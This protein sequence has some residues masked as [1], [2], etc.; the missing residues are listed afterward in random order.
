[1]N[2]AGARCAATFVVE[3]RV[4]RCR[5]EPSQKPSPLDSIRAPFQRHL[6]LNAVQLR[7]TSPSSL[8]PSRQHRLHCAEN[9]LMDAIIL[10]SQV[11]S[12]PQSLRSAKGHSPL[13]VIVWI[14]FT[15]AAGHPQ[16]Q[17]YHLPLPFLFTTVLQFCIQCACIAMCLQLAPR[18]HLALPLCMLCHKCRRRDCE[19]LRAVPTLFVPAVP[20]GTTCMH[21]IAVDL[22]MHLPM[23]SLM[24]LADYEGS[25]WLYA[26]SGPASS[27][28]NML[29]L[30]LTVFS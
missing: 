19:A 1:M 29:H 5:G 16:L 15:L 12:R 7:L 28:V 3:L 26:T 11:L 18:Y 13:W 6:R 27:V 23:H 17:D 14:T 9:T 30:P 21:R 25:S 4:T 20:A 8:Q 24:H 2:S 10:L 22:L